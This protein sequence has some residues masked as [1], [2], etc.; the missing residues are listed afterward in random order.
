MIA[1]ESKI[2]YSSEIPENSLSCMLILVGVYVLRDLVHMEGYIWV[3]EG[4]VL[5]GA[6]KLVVRNGITRRD[7]L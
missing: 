7:I 3:C 6:D 5:R 4:K 2:Y 1:V